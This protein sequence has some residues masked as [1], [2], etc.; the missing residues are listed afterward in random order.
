MGSTRNG[1]KLRIMQLTKEETKS[2]S[3]RKKAKNSGF[4][5]SNIYQN[6]G[7]DYEAFKTINAMSC[8]SVFLNQRKPYCILI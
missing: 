6:F 5:F 7:A 2:Y 8:D 1:T 4:N 3:N